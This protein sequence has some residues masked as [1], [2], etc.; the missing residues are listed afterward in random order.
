LEQ[1]ILKLAT[2]RQVDLWT[3]AFG[4]EKRLSLYQK[5]GTTAELPDEEP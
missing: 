2:R 3:N 4:E 5:S 1:V